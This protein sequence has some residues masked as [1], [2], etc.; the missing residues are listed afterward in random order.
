MCRLVYLKYHPNFL[1][2]ANR[3]PMIRISATA[4]LSDLARLDLLRDVEQIIRLV[5]HRLVDEEP[6]V[7]YYALEVLRYLVINEELEFDLV[8]RVLEKR[9]NVDISNIDSILDLDILALE[10]LVALLGEGGLEEEEED[11][12]EANENEVGGGPEASPQTIKAVSLLVNLAL[13][14]QLSIKSGVDRNNNDA[15]RL[16]CFRSLANYSAQLLGLD[17][18]AIRNWDGIHANSI[19]DHSEEIKRF[20]QLKDIV[21]IGLNF[22]KSSVEKEEEASVEELLQ[23]VSTIARTILL[24]EEDVHGSFLFKGSSTSSKSEKKGKTDKQSRVPKSVLSSLPSA[25]SIQERYESDPRSASATAALYSIGFSESE[26]IEET[27]VVM[28]KVSECFGDIVNEPLADPALLAIQT[29][30]LMQGMDKVWKTIQF[31]D[32][33]VKEELLDQ[34]VLRLEE[35]SEAYGE[36]AYIA[37]GTFLLCIGD[38]AQCWAGV[39]KMQNAIIEGKDNYLF[40]SED[41]K[42]F[43]LGMVAARLCRSAD[44]RVTDMIDTIEQSL[45]NE[46]RGTCFG[47]LFSLGIMMSNLAKGNI[48]GTDPSDTWRREQAQHIVSILLTSF[49]NC[50]TEENEVVTLASSLIKSGQTR[51]EELS[52]LCSN[53]D[54]LSVQVGYSLKMKAILIALGHSFSVLASISSDLMKCVLLI[55]NKLPWG[56]GKG[57]VL[58]AVYK[59][60]L[61]LEVLTQNDLS[62][63]LTTISNY[64]QESS[65][66]VGDALTCVASLCHLS[67][68]RSQTELDF[69]NKKVHEV[70]SDAN[71]SGDDKLMA[72]LAACAAVGELPGLAALVPAIHARV[73]KNFVGDI[74]KLLYEVASDEGEEIKLRDCSTIGLGILCAMRSSGNKIQKKCAGNMMDSFINAKEGSLM[75][76]ILQQVETAHSHLSYQSTRVVAVDKLCCL[77]STLEPIAMPGTFSKVI[78]LTLNDSSGTELKLK[79]SL[80]TLLT[81]QLEEGRRRVGFDGRGFVD[82]FTRLT[83]MPATELEVLISPEATSILM[84]ALPNLIYQ[85]PTTVAEEVTTKYLWAICK[86]SSSSHSLVQF[87]FG[88]KSIFDATNKDVKERPTSRKSISPALLR[89]IQTFIPRQVFPDL[90]NEAEPSNQVDTTRVWAAFLECLKVVPSDIVAETIMNCDVTHS[91]IFGLAICS[92]LSRKSTRRVESWISRQKANDGSNTQVLLLSILITAMQVGSETEMKDSILSLFDVMLVKGVD[93]LSLHLMA[94]KVAFWYDSREMHQKLMD[95][96]FQSVSSLS[97]FFVGDKLTFDASKLTPVLLIK[98]FDSFIADLPSKLAVLCHLLNISDD[99]SNRASRILS[100]VSALTKENDGECSK[101]GKGRKLSHCLEEIIQLINGGSLV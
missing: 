62:E 86:E 40:E 14:P 58:H 19:D 81:R 11:E 35:W 31:A 21:L 49:N 66:G 27:D 51:S 99:V 67:E 5:Q 50:L 43:C 60:S 29:C 98:L 97:S 85:I 69:V 65:N 26:L 36:H 22:A 64:I 47:P 89:T 18:E 7:L 94:A 13:L 77:L 30:S 4:A 52:V 84:S 63:T 38:S 39:A 32:E 12:E 88:V 101:Y 92:S 68:K 44:A 78:E 2:A 34:V 96:S 100:A 6:A 15:V 54:N 24:F 73:T 79:L 45:L 91:N 17:S 25:S 56:S 71:V 33:S 42:L 70:I 16:G 90:C 53:L 3:D 37:M 20:I 10:G 57:L 9:L 8:I 87:L 83:K 82:L 48:N 74:V 95:L 23:S 76:S 61:E 72:I 55:I 28:S 75:Q 41:T 46:S 59:K 93:L 80:V 1:I